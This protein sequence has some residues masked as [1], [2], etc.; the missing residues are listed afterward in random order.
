VQVCRERDA[1]GIGAAVSF[2]SRAGIPLKC[3]G[4]AQ[5]TEHID[6]EDRP[7]RLGQNQI[8]CGIST[9]VT[10]CKDCTA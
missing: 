6:R 5:K 4:Q 8:E 1:R 3:S 10:Q 7:Q 9:W 2:V